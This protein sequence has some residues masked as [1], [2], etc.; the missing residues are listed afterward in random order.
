M[1]PS[2]YPI[3][4]FCSL[5]VHQR[6][7]AMLYK[8]I[9]KRCFTQSI[10]IAKHPFEA[11][12]FHKN[13]SHVLNTSLLLSYILEF[14]CNFWGCLQSFGSLCRFHVAG[15]LCNEDFFLQ[16]SLMMNPI[17][18]FTKIHSSSMNS[19]KERQK[20]ISYRNNLHQHTHSFPRQ[21]TVSFTS[22]IALFPISSC[23][24]SLDRTFGSDWWKKEVEWQRQ[25][26]KQLTDH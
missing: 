17:T 15:N 11:S 8:P 16:Q 26:N 9:S 25:K 24:T 10:A 18:W 5:E 4:L 7:S 20:E 12:Y 3:V 23:K 2:I 14:N 13:S 21:F 19:S 22:Q 6:R 1:G